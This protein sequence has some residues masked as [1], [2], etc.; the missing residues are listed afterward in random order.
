VAYYH[1]ALGALYED[2]KGVSRDWTAAAGLYQRACEGGVARWCGALAAMYHA[3]RV[4]EEKDDATAARLHGKACDGGYPPSCGAL[5]RLYHEGSGVTKD[6]AMAASLSRKG[7]DGGGVEACGEL[8]VLYE[9]GAG[10]ARDVV[11]AAALYE[12][13]CDASAFEYCGL[14]GELYRSGRGVRSDLGRAATLLGKGCEKEFGAACMGMAELMNLPGKQ[15][16]PNASMGYYERACLLD[17]AEGCFRLGVHRLGHPCEGIACVLREGGVI[18]I[19]WSL[20]TPAQL[21]ARA[22]SLGLARAC[23]RP[24]VVNGQAEKP[25]P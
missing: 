7:C 16:N 8:G 24:E 11:K 25:R 10:V 23:A 17:Q 13:A 1:Y 4:V 2:G 18:P 15:Y 20:Q 19:A 3:R 21:F 12:R 9:A 5:G 6:D 22:C 14:L